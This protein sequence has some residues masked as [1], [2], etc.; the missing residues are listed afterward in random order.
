MI[1]ERVRSTNNV[2]ICAHL[3]CTAPAF[4]IE[5]GAHYVAFANL[6]G[7]NAA[8]QYCLV[9]LEDIWNGIDNKLLKIFKKLCKVASPLKNWKNLRMIMKEKIN[10]EISGSEIE[11]KKTNYGFR[12]ENCKQN[13]KI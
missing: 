5:E 6:E 4:I 10:N 7:P 1:V 9:C 12:N 3:F 8:P 13:E 11:Y 2:V